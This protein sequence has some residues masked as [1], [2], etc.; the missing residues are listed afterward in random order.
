MNNNALVLYLITFDELWNNVNQ[1]NYTLHV[2]ISQQKG[3]EEKGSNL[4]FYKK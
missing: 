1:D 3:E 2:I 4:F